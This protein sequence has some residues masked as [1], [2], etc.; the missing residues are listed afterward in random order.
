MIQVDAHVGKATQKNIS[1]RRRQREDFFIAPY[2]LVPSH[3]SCKR[4]VHSVRASN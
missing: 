1:F 2:V 3:S 4:V